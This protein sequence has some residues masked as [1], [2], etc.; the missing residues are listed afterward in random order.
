MDKK[1]V[2][3]PPKQ[4]LPPGNNWWYPKPGQPPLGERRDS[5]GSDDGSQPSSSPGIASP[6]LGSAFLP[7]KNMK[8]VNS[9]KNMY[10]EFDSFNF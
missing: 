1:E 7:N 3:T 9:D 6:G 8:P 4:V 5:V 2:K 10:K